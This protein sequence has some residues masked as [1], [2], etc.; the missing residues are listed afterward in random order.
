MIQG[1]LRVQ[2]IKVWFAAIWLIFS[3]AMV[4]WWWNL[5]LQ[6]IRNSASPEAH[7]KYRMFMWEG[8]FFLG[9]IVIGGCLLI[10]YMFQELHRQ[11]QVKNFFSVFSHDLKTSISRLRLQADVLKE[12]ADLAG[13]TQLNSLVENIN[14]LDLQLE[15]ALFLAQEGQLHLLQEKLQLSKL[16]QSLRNEWGELDISL[17]SEAELQ[18]DQRAL[19]SV[20]RNILQNAVLH[21]KADRMSIRPRAIATGKVALLFCDNGQGYSGDLEGLG[22]GPRFSTHSQ[23][24]GIGLYLTRL[25]LKEQGGSVSFKKLEGISGLCVELTLKGSLPEV[26]A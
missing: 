10:Y 15:N 9:A 3:T 16:I 12:K 17:E 23:G 5:G 25:L 13:S 4:L 20:I 11:K 7:T 19:K 14:R 24:N 22:Q 21:G 8:G 18:G 26:A 1:Q 6:E 2:T